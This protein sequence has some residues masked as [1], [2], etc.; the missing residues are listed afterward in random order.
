MKLFRGAVP[1]IWLAV[2]SIPPCSAEQPNLDRRTT[3]EVDSASPRD[4]FGSLARTLGC[5]LAMAPEIKQP[6]TMRLTNVTVR[7]A[8]NAISESI[9]CHWRVQGTLL[10]VD[11]GNAGSGGVVGGVRGGVVG[12]VPGGVVGGVPG[13]VVGGVPGGVVGGVD[14][15][16]R[17]ERKTPPNFRFENAL[18][19]DV[20]IA[21]G[22]IADLETRMEGSA[23]DRRITVD[24][25]DCTVLAAFRIIQQ[26]VGLNQSVVFAASV[27]GSD[28]K[29][30]FKLG[31]Q[32][33]K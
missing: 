13:G 30:L 32:K 8:L 2:M 24:L 31:P 1:A 27:P 3:I 5:D 15:K 23:A 19:G 17:L 14:F 6:V 12:G 25:G 11:L 7:T 21:L 28:Q 9:G 26:Q 18:I 4:V 10:Q 33:K 16:Q 22:K 29:M 20:M